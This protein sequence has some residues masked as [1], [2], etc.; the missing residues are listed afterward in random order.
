M[1][2]KI[3]TILKNI[4][5]VIWKEEEADVLMTSYKYEHMPPETLEQL[6]YRTTFDKLYP[7]QSHVIPYYWMPKWS[8]TN[9]AS[10]R[11]LKLY[12]D[13]MKN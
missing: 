4:A 12:A 7:N 10:A 11:T 5:I 6:Y 8:T 13:K 9:D 3:E 1:F 2:P